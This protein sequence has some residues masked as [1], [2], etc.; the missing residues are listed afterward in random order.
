MGIDGECWQRHERFAVFHHR[1]E[2]TLA[3]RQARRF[4]QG[5]QGH[6]GMYLCSVCVCGAQVV[7]AIENTSTGSQDRPNKDVVITDC[8][9]LA[10]EEPYAV[11]KAPSDESV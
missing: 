3:G 10:V 5:R 11:E 9:V 7:R 2:D 1:Q 8:G 6:E 4:R